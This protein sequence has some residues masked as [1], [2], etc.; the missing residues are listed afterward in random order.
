MFRLVF[1]NT[2]DFCSILYPVTLLNLLTSSG[3]FG[4]LLGVLYVG[5][6]VTYDRHGFIS[7]LLMCV[8]FVSLLHG[9]GLLA[10]CS[11]RMV[12]VDTLA[13]LLAVGFL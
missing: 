1:R 7:S 6:H 8:L 10:Q 5:N 2:V 4:R 9:L 3:I 12:R 13:L 11:V